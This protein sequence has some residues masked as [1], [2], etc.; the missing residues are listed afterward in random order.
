MKRRVLSPALFLLSIILIMVHGVIPHSHH[1]RLF[2][3]VVDFLGE[4]A[5]KT[6]DHHNSDSDVSDKNKG[7]TLFFEIGFH[8][9]FYTVN[10]TVTNQDNSQI[11]D[12][13]VIYSYFIVPDTPDIGIILPSEHA[14][15][16]P[17]VVNVHMSFASNALGLRA[18]PVC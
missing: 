4:D 3:S 16:T 5:Q 14:V 9:Q 15:H 10:Q 6:F 2:S 8:E 17:Y 18:P 12:N 11:N 7:Q 1:N 13:S